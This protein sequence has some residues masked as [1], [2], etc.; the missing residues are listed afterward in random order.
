LDLGSQDTVRV[1]L[2]VRGESGPLL[3]G[4]VAV[5]Q[6]L[7][8]SD[9]VNGGYQVD[10]AEYLFAYQSMSRHGVIVQVCRLTPATGMR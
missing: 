3:V 4:H 5:G 6:T 7:S 1:F 10:N 9:D 8:A 2:G